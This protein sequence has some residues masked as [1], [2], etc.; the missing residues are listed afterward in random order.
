MT[1]VSLDYAQSQFAVVIVVQAEM[2][3]V[4][5]CLDATSAIQ[6]AIDRS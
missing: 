4:K 2:H 6:L 5:H 1:I 3:D